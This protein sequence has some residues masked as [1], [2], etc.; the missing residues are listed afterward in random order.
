MENPRTSGKIHRTACP[1]C[2]A[3]VESRDLAADKLFPFCSR[4]CKMIDLGKW[5]NGEYR[6]S[7]ELPD[8]EKD[9]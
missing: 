6:F 3:A 5:F 9:K 4:K 1:I 7:H 8:D 2:K